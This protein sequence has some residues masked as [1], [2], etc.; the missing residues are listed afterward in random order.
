MPP[1]EHPALAQALLRLSL[2]LDRRHD[3]AED[4]PSYLELAVR[5]AG[6]EAQLD[7][8]ARLLVHLARR[9]EGASWQEIGEAMGFTRQTAYKRW[10]TPSPND[11]ETDSESE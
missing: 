8:L 6:L 7:D 9:H 1:V 5:V 10:G 4:A 2:A 3:G 11:H